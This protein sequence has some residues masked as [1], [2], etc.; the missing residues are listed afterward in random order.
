MQSL[1]NIY[2]TN[3]NNSIDDKYKKI[4]LKDSIGNPLNFNLFYI[5]KDD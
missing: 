4:I 3:N 5:F 1:S 2:I